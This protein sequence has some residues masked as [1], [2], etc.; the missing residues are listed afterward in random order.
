MAFLEG[1]HNT[2]K[3]FNV[4]TIAAG[5]SVYSDYIALDHRSSGHGI[6]G[7][8]TSGAG[9]LSVGYALSGAATTEFEKFQSWSV[10]GALTRGTFLKTLTM[11]PANYIRFVAVETGGGSSVVLTMFFTQVK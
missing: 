3:A 1:T 2:L 4:E 9:T 5:T 11:R 8:V 10:T 6:N 7:V